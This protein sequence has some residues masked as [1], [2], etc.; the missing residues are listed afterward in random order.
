MG[1]VLRL[2]FQGLP[3]E[4]LRDR[5]VLRISEC[6]W[7]LARG[8]RGFFDNNGLGG[9]PLQLHAHT[10]ACKGSRGISDFTGMEYK[11]GKF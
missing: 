4:G 10:A 6:I 11:N 9:R 3:A 1:I 8:K 5:S 2:V 7:K